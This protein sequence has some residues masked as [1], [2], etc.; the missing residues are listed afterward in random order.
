MVVYDS[1]LGTRRAL[2]SLDFRPNA[3]ALTHS[4]VQGYHRE[5]PKLLSLVEVSYV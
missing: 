3:R 5:R 2:R 4:L 1:V